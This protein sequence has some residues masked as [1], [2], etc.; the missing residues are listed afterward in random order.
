[1]ND[2]TT[3]RTT[4]PG[5]TGGA[6]SR[7]LTKGLHQLACPPQPWRRRAFP[8][9]VRSALGAD[10]VGSAS[11]QPPA[12]TCPPWRSVQHP[13]STRNTVSSRIARKSFKTLG[14]AARYPEL[15]T[16]ALQAAARAPAIPN[17]QLQL[18]EAGLTHR[19]QTPAILS[20]R[21]LLGYGHFIT[22]GTASRTDDAASNCRSLTT[23]HYL[24]ITGRS[25]V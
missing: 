8:P 18:L 14:D 25:H 19:K 1:M 22:T 21:Q 7:T 5:A 6:R 11:L 24:L 10:G 12:T 15:E 3:T 2:A 17:R 13:E 23:S 9:L 16:A 4:E 20:N